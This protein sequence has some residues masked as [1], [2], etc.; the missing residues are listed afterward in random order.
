GVAEAGNSCDSVSLAGFDGSLP[1]H[2]SK[3]ARRQEARRSRSVQ[4]A[5]HRACIYAALHLGELRL[6]VTHMST[7]SGNA[8]E[9]RS[10][11]TI[12]GIVIGIL[13]TLIF[14]AANVYFGLKAGLTFATSIP[15]AVISMAILRKVGSAT[16][17]ENN[18]VQTIA[19]SAGCLSAIIFVLPG[20]VIVGWWA[21]FPYWQTMLICALGGILGVMYS[22]PLR[23]ALVTGSDLPYPEGVACA[24]VLKVG[25]QH[26]QNTASAGSSE[27]DMEAGK[28]GFL[29]VLWGS[30]VSA[31][32]QI[33]EATH[34]FGS[35]VAGYFHTGDRGGTGFNFSLSLALLGVG[36]LVGLW[37]GVSMLIGT[38]IAWGWAMPHFSALMNVPG[39]L[40][41]LISYTYDHKVRFLGAG[42]IGAAA[43]WAL[44]RL[45]KPV[46]TGLV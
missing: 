3:I 46:T 26:R 32:F 37:V 28:A 14:T 44:L 18:I 10:E 39:S 27:A 17:Q 38:A 13:I 22:I 5:R 16:I 33:V 20:L 43:I 2:F 36:H 41:D 25:D 4:L 34:I 11:L 6:G 23:R 30:I 9:P 12:R 7:P 29:A 45:V 24:E 1:P 35:S 19:S 40:T 31:L 42:T 8:L 21:D 15:A